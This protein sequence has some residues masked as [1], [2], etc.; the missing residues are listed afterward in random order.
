MMK[1]VTDKHRTNPTGHAALALWQRS[2]A[3]AG[4]NE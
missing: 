2:V 4:M 3:L 1:R